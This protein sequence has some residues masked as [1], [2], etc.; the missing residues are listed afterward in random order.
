MSPACYQ[1]KSDQPC[2]DFRDTSEQH[3]VENMMTDLLHLLELPSDL[4]VAFLEL[5]PAGPELLPRVLLHLHEPLMDCA[6]L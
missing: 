5:L 3:P 6:D 4:V 1:K 2:T